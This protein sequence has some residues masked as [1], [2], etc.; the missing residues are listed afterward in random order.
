MMTR[1]IRASGGTGALRRDPGQH[2]GTR[3]RL[4]EVAQS[5]AGSPACCPVASPARPAI[6][7]QTPV[8]A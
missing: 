5:G 7:A 3:D 2:A 4:G 8:T 1:L 6:I